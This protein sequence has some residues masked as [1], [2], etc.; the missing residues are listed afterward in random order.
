MGWNHQLDYNPYISKVDFVSQTGE[1]FNQL[2]ND[3]Y[4]DRY[5]HFQPD[6]PVEGMFIS[7]QWN[8]FLL[9]RPGPWKK[10]LNGLFSLLNIRHPQKFKAV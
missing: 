5:D 6:T 7:P 9:S 4:I 2:T 10:K 3:R 1:I 8:P